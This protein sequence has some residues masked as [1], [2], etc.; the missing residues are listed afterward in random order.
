VPTPIKTLNA[1]S[2]PKPRRRRALILI[3][4]IAVVIIGTFSALSYWVDLLWFQSLGYS[5]V[6]WRANYLKL[7]IF[8]AF[9]A[10]TF[11]IV[12]AALKALKHTVQQDLP[13]SREI[14]LQG[15]TIT[16]SIEPVLR[17][18]TWAV[19]LIAGFLAGSSMLSDWPT[20]ALFLYAP[21]TTTVADPIF[22]RPLSFFLFTLPA[23]ELLLDWVITLAVVIG[24]ASIVLTALAASTRAL[25]KDPRFDAPSP[26]RGVSLA[27][28]F[29]LLV[30]AANT[31]ADRFQLLLDHHTIFDGANYTDAHIQIPGLL[32]IA[33]ALVLGAILAA[34][35]AFRRTRAAGLV[36]AVVPAIGTFIILGIVNWYVSSF[37]VKP[38]ELDRETPYIAQNIDMTRKAYGLDSFA[39]REFPAETT[40]E[41]TD[42]AN[43]QPTLQNIRLWDWQALRDALR[44]EQ[45]IRTYYD[46]PDIDI[47]RYSIDG[48]MRE[49]M[50][51][52]RELNVDKLPVSSRNWIN[53]KLIYT[54]GY[55][56]TMNSVN[57]FTPE[58]LP[59]LILSNM[60]V[61]STIPSL[62]VARPEIYFG[63]LTNTDVYVKTAQKEFDYPNGQN[64][65]LTSY[66]GTGGIA[67][68]SFLRRILL[69]FELN[70]LG[71]LP[72][73][74]DVKP[75]SR[76]L[77]HRN[78]EERIAALAPFLTFD[79]DPYIIVGDDGRLSWIIDAFTTSDNYPDSTHFAATNT[80]NSDG[81]PINYMRNSVKVVIDAYN[82]TTTFYTFDTQ[83]PVLAAYSHIFP[84]LFQPAASM[85]ADLKKHIR[86][87]EPLFK[88][89]STVYG[90]Y[91]MTNP[92][93]FFN[94][95]DLWTVATE[96]GFD[97]NNQQATQAMQP[98][99]VLMKLPGEASEEFVE[100]LPF[101]PANRNNL[102]GWIAARSDGANYGTAIVYDFPKTRLIDGPQQIEARIDQNAQLSGQLTLWNQQG[103][104]VRRGSLLVI[105]SGKALLYAE[106]IYLQ[107]EQSPMPELRL[108]VLALQ[109]RLAYGPTFE[110]ALASL[111]NGA[112]STVR[113]ADTQSAPTP[114]SPAAST[115]TAQPTSTATDTKG[116]IA[117][118]G[119]DF[120]DYQRLTAE[121]KLSEAGQKLDD[122]K[123][124]LEKLNA[125]TK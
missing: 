78:I 45:E 113:A 33:L 103:S 15:Q 93:V 56:L 2:K 53:E 17:V 32:F 102:I 37:V 114:A 84:T 54:H 86:Y 13:P 52:A 34:L 89:Q 10:L 92:E 23:W 105:P 98:N 30:L 65:T 109:D 70:D 8:A 51:A 95:E 91:H 67:I 123:R 81:V 26:W 41:A 19:A 104:H 74:D 38:N 27:L 44:Q 125:T 9:F 116:L 79:K 64:N 31:Y 124:T 39:Q 101:T 62:S 83:D 85:P 71:K 115:S 29:F 63:Q 49:V 111:Y 107:A 100:I 12:F 61:Q 20:L 99:Y 59:T 35:N 58:G 43:N 28:S 110:A 72:F 46:F 77:I 76:L 24:I 73:S 48:H 18:A 22:N 94:R 60:P 14:V 96:N 3:A 6:F 21:H 118:A 117:Q 106:P 88:L 50:L 36:V 7:G 11:A 47:D 112:A 119:R 25:N 40:V 1:N 4:I 108:V 16:L 87:P 122:L 97:S 42:P 5:E 68:G 69:A 120:N 66:Q 82:G 121:G 57:G 55:G 75:D 80:A 90:L